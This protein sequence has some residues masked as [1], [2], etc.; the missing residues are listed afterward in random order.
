MITYTQGKKHKKDKIVFVNGHQITYKELAEIMVTFYQN[1]ENIYPRPRF[2]GG[3]YF[4]DFIRDCL[5][6][7]KV[8]K[9]ILVKYKLE[10]K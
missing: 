6:E 9:E 2:K 7:G 3:E 10:D 8:T 4:A 1:E 5:S